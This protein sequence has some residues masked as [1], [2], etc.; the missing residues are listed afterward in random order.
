MPIRT[1]LLYPGAVAGLGAPA[2]TWTFGDLAAM[3]FEIR[4]LVSKGS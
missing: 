1:W 3:T 4:T 2:A